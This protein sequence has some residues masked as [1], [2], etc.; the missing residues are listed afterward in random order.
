MWHPKHPR[1]AKPGSGGRE[2]RA[3]V[4]PIVPLMAQ[5]AP[6]VF[7]APAGDLAHSSSW[8]F[9]V[10]CESAPVVQRACVSCGTSGTIAWSGPLGRHHTPPLVFPEQ[11]F[12]WEEAGTLTP[13]KR[14]TV[15]LNLDPQSGVPPGRLG[16]CN[17]NL[18]CGASC[19]ITKALFEAP[20]FSS[21]TA[22]P[23]HLSH[24]GAGGKRTLKRRK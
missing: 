21:G 6:Q 14:A 20:F 7:Q 24:P 23:G 1:W 4:V 2:T 3:G 8:G 10:E 13:Q 22:G 5:L 9:R 18:F 19:A 11:V 16:T 15:P 12:G 17:A